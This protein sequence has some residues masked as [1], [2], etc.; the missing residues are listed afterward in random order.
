MSTALLMIH[1][2]NL[3]PLA[4][5]L[6]YAWRESGL[7]SKAIII[8]LFLGSMFAWSV[9][10]N[11]GLSL[12]HAKREAR[13]FLRFYRSHKEPL[14]AYVQKFHAT[15]CP[16]LEVYR[17]GAKEAVRQLGGDTDRGAELFAEN[18]IPEGRL[19]VG[20]ID[21]IQDAV[22]REINT[23]SLILESYLG[24]LATA[25][26]AG[27]LMGLLG[28]VWGIM[29]AFGAMAVVGTAT[30]SAVA[31]GISGA[32]I[33]TVIGLLVAIPSLI[34]YNVL[35]HHVER[36]TVEIENFA[37]EFVAALETRYKR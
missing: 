10:I 12:R 3:P 22:D 5:G 7:Y 9:M 19:D 26:S 36:Q 37:T 33:T 29:D 31:P 2:V 34:G 13:R 20:Q 28:T 6:S 17:A 11:K 24:A 18:R 8:L 32:L 35:I 25:V 14:A 1:P 16:L 27:P 15:E 30:I 23:Q 21:R 4:A